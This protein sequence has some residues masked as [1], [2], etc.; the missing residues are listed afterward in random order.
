MSTIEGGGSGSAAL[1]VP[2]AVADT[3][4]G[5]GAETSDESPGPGS[6]TLCDN[7]PAT[8]GLIEWKGQVIT[9]ELGLRTLYQVV[10]RFETEEQAAQ[11]LDAYA[12]TNDCESWLV[13]TDEPGTT[14]VVYTALQTT[15]PS[16]G[17]RAR[18]FEIVGE[19]DEVPSIHTRVLLIQSGTDV[20][21]LSLTAVNEDQIAELD[22]L[23]PLA[24][25]RLGYDGS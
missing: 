5:D 13:E 8:D 15:P 3:S 19:M 14:D 20:L 18:Q 23:A 6:E 11:Y 25:E 24:V 2:L 7:V 22:D 17:D 12:G 9:T 10:S 21:G 4:F 16:Y 1:T